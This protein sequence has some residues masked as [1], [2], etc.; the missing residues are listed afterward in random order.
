[1]RKIKR[2]CI[3]AAAGNMPLIAIEE[4]LRKKI[5]LIIIGFKHISEFDKLRRYKNIPVYETQIASF[6]QNLKVLQKEKADSILFS[7]KVHKVNVFKIMRFDLVTLKAFLKLK[8][9]SDASI[10]QGI[11]DF[12]ASKGIKTVSQK[13]FYSRLIMPKGF[14][15]RKKCSRKLMANLQWGRAMAARIADLNI[16]QSIIIGNHVVIS[17]EGIEGTDEMIKRSQSILLKENCFIKVARKKQDVRY[18]LPVFGLQTLS[19][20]NRV[21][22]KTIALGSGMVLIPEM[23]KVVAQANKNKMV[24]YG[25]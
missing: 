17:V 12:Y 15:T 1:M 5:N 18:D 8:D 9:R 7:G 24:I 20:L 25:I 13:D 23:A 19:L 3:M 21:G 11:V 2:L 16:G 10:M 14:L 4:A 22:I 6:S